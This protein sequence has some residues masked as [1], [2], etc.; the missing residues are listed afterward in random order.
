MV[1]LGEALGQVSDA[2]GQSCSNG[3]SQK[4]Y[5]CVFSVVTGPYKTAKTGPSAENRHVYGTP[6]SSVTHVFLSCARRAIFAFAIFSG[7]RAPPNASCVSCL[8]R[9]FLNICGAAWTSFISLCA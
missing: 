1:E 5:V 8:W 2:E 9:E 4:P 3:A 7:S 6:D